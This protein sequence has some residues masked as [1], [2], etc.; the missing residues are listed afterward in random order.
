MICVHTHKEGGSHSRNTNR[1]V[2]IQRDGT[3][4]IDRGQSTW[5]K[6]YDKTLGINFRLSAIRNKGKI[7]CRGKHLME[8]LYL[9]YLAH[10]N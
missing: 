10:L 3:P 5:L 8:D 4:K 1:P 2:V 6:S 9:R 7:L